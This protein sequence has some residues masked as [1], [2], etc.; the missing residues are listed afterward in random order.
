VNRIEYWRAS[1]RMVDD[2]GQEIPGVRV[3][4]EPPP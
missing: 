2:Q 4:L 1:L 3:T